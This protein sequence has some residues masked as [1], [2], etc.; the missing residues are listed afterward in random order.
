METILDTVSPLKKKQS[1]ISRY[2]NFPVVFA[3]DS[4][5]SFAS[6]PSRKVIL[7]IQT[8]EALGWY[9]YSYRKADIIAALQRIIAATDNEQLRHEVTK[10]VRRLLN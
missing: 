9:L 3:I 1:S 10:S 7:R 5:L 6:D 2:R 8:I 4:L